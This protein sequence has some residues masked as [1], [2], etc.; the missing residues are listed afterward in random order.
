MFVIWGE[1]RQA[2]MPSAFMPISRLTIMAV[3]NER[4]ICATASAGVCE[5]VALRRKMFLTVRY[6]PPSNAAGCSER[7]SL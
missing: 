1:R 7:N 6:S 5:V 2:L 4:V 3:S